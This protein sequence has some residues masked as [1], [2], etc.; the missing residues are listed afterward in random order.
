MLFL[1]GCMALILYIL[2]QTVTFFITCLFLIGFLVVNCAELAYND[3][4][5]ESKNT[6]ITAKLHFPQQASSQV[7]RSLGLAF[8][9]FLA[10]YVRISLIHVAHMCLHKTFF[11]TS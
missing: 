4:F 10:I 3:T 1:M 9:S 2:K 5:C 6:L 11:A 7:E 8:T